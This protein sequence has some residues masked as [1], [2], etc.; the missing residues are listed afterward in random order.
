MKLYGTILLATIISTTTLS[1][2]SKNDLLTVA[3][4]TGF[5]STSHY[6]DVV[7]FI[8]RFTFNDKVVYW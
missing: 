2:Q 5:E 3:E 4:K 1:A 7:L 6:D 8:D